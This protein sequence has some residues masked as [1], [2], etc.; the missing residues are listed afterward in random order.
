MSTPIGIYEKVAL[1]AFPTGAHLKCA[2]PA[3]DRGERIDATT[4]AE[5]L[6]RGWPMHC[7]MTMAL[8]EDK[9]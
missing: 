8:V 5:Y 4:A 2:N 9:R 7:G 1:A 3:C 6:A